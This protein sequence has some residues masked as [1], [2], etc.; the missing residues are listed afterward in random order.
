MKIGYTGNLH[1]RFKDISAHCPFKPV[2]EAAII[3]DQTLERLL[4]KILGEYRMR[5]EWFR[6]EG[7]VVKVVDAMANNDLSAVA[8]DIRKEIA[9]E[10]LR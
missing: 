4:H 3:G 10:N 5:Y 9:I 2:I 8:D 6:Y 7:L 1:Q